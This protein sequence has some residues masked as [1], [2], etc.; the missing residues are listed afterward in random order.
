LNSFELFGINIVAFMFLI[1]FPF[2]VFL[3]NSQIGKFIIPNSNTMLKGLIGSS[4]IASIGSI[5]VSYSMINFQKFMSF[6]TL[7]Q[8][9]ILISVFR[10]KKFANFMSIS[11]KY[12]RYFLVY[13]IITFF[14]LLPYILDAYRNIDQT[15]LINAHQTYYSGQVI[16][17]LNGNYPGRIR[18]YDQYP[19]TWTKYHFFQSA[20]I[21][22]LF[23]NFNFININYFSFYIVKISI[24]SMI[25]TSIYIDGKFSKVIQNVL[26][27]LTL[28]IVFLTKLISWSI[29]TNNIIPGLILVLIYK[30]FKAKDYLSFYALTLINLILV[31]RSI[32]FSITLLIIPLLSNNHS[33]LGFSQVRFSNY[34]KKIRT[35]FWPQVLFSISFASAGLVMILSGEKLVNFNLVQIP[36]PNIYEVTIKFLHFGWLEILPGVQLFQINP[37]DLMS[38]CTL[39]FIIFAYFFRRSTVRVNLF[40]IINFLVFLTSIL[41]YSN[42]P[43]V[44]PGMLIISALLCYFFIPASLFLYV[45]PLTHRLFFFLLII[46]AYLSIMLLESG[47][48]IPLYS[49]LYFILI[50][51]LTLKISKSKI[52]ILYPFIILY[53]TIL[54]LT[55]ALISSPT[56]KIH[57]FSLND[58]TSHLINVTKIESL[59]RPTYLCIYKD[60]EIGL[61]A[62]LL[63]KGP[64]YFDSSMSDR[65]FIT[66]NFTA[67]IINVKQIAVVCPQ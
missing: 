40:F 16:E 27:F 43:A 67:Q 13:L 55:Y 2:I 36:P 29:L 6:V 37:F 26:I 56:K 41:V 31:S 12:I 10:Y 39:C 48:S 24:V 22:T 65:F 54:I 9:A 34:F 60:W 50:Y 4:L 3:L 23:P 62:A 19:L 5:F 21:S 1:T 58:S 57:Q 45:I 52:V 63:G 7:F 35:E 49:T 47:L 38:F 8:I 32:I 46:P 25:I 11:K 20:L 44:Q 42:F 61:S 59:Q 15:F 33:Y 17:M 30:S 64:I 51:E 14:I 28:S 53:V 66:K 18:V